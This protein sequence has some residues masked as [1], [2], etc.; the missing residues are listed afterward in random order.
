MLQ[1]RSHSVHTD[2]PPVL[3][4]PQALAPTLPAAE[5]PNTAPPAPQ[6]A[7][8]PVIHKLTVEAYHALWHAGHLAEND[9]IELVDGLLI[10]MPPLGHP[11]MTLVN[12][13]NRLL[14]RA[15]GD[16]AVVSV[17]NSISLPPWSEPQ[18]DVVLFEPRF[19][20]LSAGKP[21]AA[22]A[23]LVIEVSDSNLRYDRTTK[24]SL[25]AREGIR[26]FWI[27]DVF[28]EAIEVCRN[29]AR[30]GDGITYSER[31]RYGRGE[32]AVVGA[33]PAV[34]VPVDDVFG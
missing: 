11:H 30:T 2:Y 33:L 18:P 16:D 20:S 25:Y 17:Q 26:E 15:T 12:R 29:P 19:I 24:L 5:P 10:E 14:V 27:V 4:A 13:L 21:S 3:E 1:T 31:I 8:R 32:Q 9:R 23:L 6:T 22:D 34:V 7:W 28:A